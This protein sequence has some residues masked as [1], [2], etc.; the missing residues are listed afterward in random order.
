MKGGRPETA[1]GFSLLELV[2][3]ILILG[4]L[5]AVGLPL[6]MSSLDESRLDAAAQEVATALRFARYRAQTSG[7]PMRVT[8]DPDTDTITVEQ[9]V[10]PETASLLDTGLSTLPEV[11]VEAATVYATADYPPKPG[12]PYSISFGQERR[13]EGVDL[14]SATVG[15]VTFGS[16]GTPSSATTVQLARRGRSIEVSITAAGAL[17]DGQ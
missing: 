9:G 4:I 1:S 8:L 16:A 12:A 10:H 6:L 7:Q 2:I 13:F 14:V 11:T 17:A 15:T 5:A 3:V